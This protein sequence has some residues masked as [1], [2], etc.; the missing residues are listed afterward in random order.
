VTTVP[1]GA[2]AGQPGGRRLAGV[3][4]AA[5][6][7][8]ALAVQA[9]VNGHLGGA[10]NADGRH[11]TLSGVVVAFVSFGSGLVLLVAYVLILPAGRRGLRRLSGALRGHRLKWWQCV[12]GASGAFL[13]TTQGARGG[14]RGG[15]PVR[16]PDLSLLAARHC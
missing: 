7:G 2:Q 6:G 4:L 13:V 12:G 1:T 11:S 15:Q 16:A 14:D 3:A 8:F 9:R 5:F 10:L